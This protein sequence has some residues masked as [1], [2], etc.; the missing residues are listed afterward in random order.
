M[1]MGDT[2]SSDDEI[3]KNLI[4]NPLEGTLKIAS[5]CIDIFSY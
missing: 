1:D 5:S 3:K 4:S 2:V